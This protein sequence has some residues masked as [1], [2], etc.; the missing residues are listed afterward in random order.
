FGTWSK[1]SGY[2]VIRPNASGV[3]RL[4]WADQSVRQLAR[5]RDADVFSYVAETFDH[6]PD[7]FVGADLKA[8]KPVASTN[9]FQDRFAWGRSELV[10]YRTDKGERLQ[11][12]LYYP[13]NYEA[14]KRYPMIV[15]MYEKLSDSVHRYVAPSDRAE[16]NITAF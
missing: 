12:A 5:A 9:P 13:A 14:G 16:A 10:E 7:L 8:A 3:E 2:G 1:K 4:I 6:S 15:Y 11:G